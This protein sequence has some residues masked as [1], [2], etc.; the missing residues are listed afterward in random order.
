[1]AKLGVNIDHIATI[2]EARKTTEPDMVYASFLAEMAGCDGITIHLREDERHIKKEDVYTLKK[3]YR[4]SP[5]F[6]NIPQSRYYRNCQKSKTTFGLSSAREP[7]RGDYRGRIRYFIQ[8]IESERYDKRIP[9]PG[10]KSLFIHRPR[11]PSSKN[12]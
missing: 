11:K 2:R 10:Y 12:L 6:G 9:R 7:T 5:Q 8:P 4:H 3:A 1:M